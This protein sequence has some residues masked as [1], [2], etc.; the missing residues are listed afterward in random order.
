MRIELGSEGLQERAVLGVERADA[1]EALVMM[2]DLALA[3]R[4][5]AP[6]PQH[7]VEEG[8]HVRHPLRPPE[9]DEEK[10]V[11]GHGAAHFSSQA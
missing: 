7:V 6:A 5:D 3:L 2:G 4:G 10:R 11:V 8:H 1:P 9:G